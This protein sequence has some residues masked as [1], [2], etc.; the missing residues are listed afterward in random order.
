VIVRFD[1]PPPADLVEARQL[2]GLESL[3]ERLHCPLCGMRITP[4]RIAC[5]DWDAGWRDGHVEATCPPCG[6]RGVH[7]FDLTPIGVFPWLASRLAGIDLW[8]VGFEESLVETKTKERVRMW[9]GGG[10]EVIRLRHAS[11]PRDSSGSL[12]APSVHLQVAFDLAQ[13]A[14]DPANAMR[15]SRLLAERRA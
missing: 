10:G 5:V 11:G 14:T 7:A 3:W 6:H 13:P 1:V 9:T 15:W 2:P 8:R 12:A 4:S